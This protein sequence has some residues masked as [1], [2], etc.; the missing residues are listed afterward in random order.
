MQTQTIGIVTL[1]LIIKYFDSI[2]A[3]VSFFEPHQHLFYSSLFALQVPIHWKPSNVFF[4]IHL[5]MT[6]K[7][8]EQSMAMFRK[9]CI[10]KVGVRNGQ[11]SYIIRY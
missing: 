11:S 9:N 8:I 5:K 3:A 2:D 6:M 7:Q 4:F 10:E 1:I